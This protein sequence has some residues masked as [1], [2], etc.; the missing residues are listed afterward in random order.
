M[1]QKQMH[2]TAALWIVGILA[3]LL[4]LL[5][6]SSGCRVVQ[7]PAG[8]VVQVDPNAAGAITTGLD[9]VTGIL[10]A[11]SMIWPALAGIASTLAGIGIV[12]KTNIKPKLT[13]AQSESE[14]WRTVSASLVQAIEVF[15]QT[16]P[17][18]WEKLKEQIESIRKR[19][20]FGKDWATI[21]GCIEELRG[22]SPDY[23]NMTLT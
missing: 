4:M 17:E 16:Q 14:M 21:K 1:N 11:L 2:R 9:T 10:G 7:T 23:F 20:A 12:W 3:L 22:L 18:Q 5:A 19:L 6:I 15:K 13:T 8:A